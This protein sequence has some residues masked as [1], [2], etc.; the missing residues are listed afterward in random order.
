MTYTPDWYLW[1]LGGAV[2][3]VV[4]LFL[5]GRSV[6]AIRAARGWPAMVAPLVIRLALAAAAF[7]LA[8]RHGAL[9]LVLMLGGFLAPRTVALRRMRE[10]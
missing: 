8:A 2:L 9:P 6:A 7:Y 5:I 4:Y 1:I 10:G 3:G